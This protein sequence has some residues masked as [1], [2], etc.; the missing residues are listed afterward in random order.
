MAVNPVCWVE[1]Y[2][3]DMQ[4][5]KVFY[6]GVLGISLAPLPYPDMEM[7]MFPMGDNAP[8]A[9]GALVHMP[10]VSSGGSGTLVYFACDD[11]AVEEARVA[12]FG[13]HVQQPKMSIGEYGFISLVLDP[14]G[15]RLG[16]FSQ[17]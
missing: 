2:V 13:G 5:A 8:G 10:G 15:N 17:R 14:D 12:Q 1:I 16:L 11:C 9:S 7:W 6:E 4:R 3:Q